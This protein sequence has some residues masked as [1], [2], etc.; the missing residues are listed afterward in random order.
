MGMKIV[1]NIAK[2]RISKRVFQ[3][4]KAHQI[5]RKMNISYSLIR[6]Y[7]SAY[8]GVISVYFSEDLVCFGF[9]LETPVLR[10]ALLPYYRRKQS[11]D[12]IFP[13]LIV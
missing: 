13:L 2:R 3:E 12:K 11:W 1:G 8:Q 10:F 5:F 6:T 7:T 9:F 4:T